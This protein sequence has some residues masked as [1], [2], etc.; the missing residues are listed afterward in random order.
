MASESFEAF[1]SSYVFLDN[2]LKMHRDNTG[3]NISQEDLDRIWGRF[4]K[5]DSSRNRNSGGTRNRSCAS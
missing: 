3:D 2:D 5:V 4:Y 1:I